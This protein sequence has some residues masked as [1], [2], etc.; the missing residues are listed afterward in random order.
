MVMILN[1]N[2]AYIKFCIDKKEVLKGP[3]WA[4]LMYQLVLLIIQSI[5]PPK[6]PNEV[7][8]PS[9]PAPLVICAHMTSLI[10]V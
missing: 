9:H 5:Q 8:L 4:T 1:F 3:F 7:W 6:H 2:E 10:L